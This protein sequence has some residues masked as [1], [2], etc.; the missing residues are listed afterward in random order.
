MA[1]GS[2]WTCG[3]GC[4]QEGRAEWLEGKGREEEAREVCG[5]SLQK[6]LGGLAVGVVDSLIPGLAQCVKDLALL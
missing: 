5:T 1:P 3:P 6:A 2:K 4:V